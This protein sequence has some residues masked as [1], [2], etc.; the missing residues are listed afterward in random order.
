MSLGF[1][2]WPKKREFGDGLE[3]GVKGFVFGLLMGD[4]YDAITI[5]EFQLIMEGEK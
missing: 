3:V 4:F 2:V 5:V 1:T